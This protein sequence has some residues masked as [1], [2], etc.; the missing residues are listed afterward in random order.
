MILAEGDIISFKDETN[1]KIGVITNMIGA[2]LIEVDFSDGTASKIDRI[3]DAK[4]IKFATEAEKEKAYKAYHKFE[5]DRKDIRFR[6]FLDALYDCVELNNSNKFD[7]RY[8]NEGFTNLIEL[9]DKEEYIQDFL[10]R[11]VGRGRET[12][13]ME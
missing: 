1:I 3:K 13:I 2:N 6:E 8:S 9:F 10:M 12:R 7:I 5:E 11:F 4:A